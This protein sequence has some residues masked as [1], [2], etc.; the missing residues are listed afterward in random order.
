[1]FCAGFDASQLFCI[2]QYRFNFSVTT[3]NFYSNFQ[4]LLKLSQSKNLSCEDYQ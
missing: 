1:M 3:L 2:L 4:A